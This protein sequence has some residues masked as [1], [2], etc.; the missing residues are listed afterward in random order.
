[1]P[2]SAE[3]FVV[4]VD[5]IAIEIFIIVVV[6]FISI[7]KVGIADSSRAPFGYVKVVYVKVVPR[8]ARDNFDIAHRGNFDIAT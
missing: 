2:A 4:V 3:H 1:M 7:F 8:H 6:T 5:S